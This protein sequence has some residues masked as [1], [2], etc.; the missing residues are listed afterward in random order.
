MQ[1]R[2]AIV[3]DDARVREELAKLINRA[4]GFRCVGTYADGET[5]LS[6]IPLKSPM[7][8]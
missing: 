6:E 1:V 3:E 5:A 8:S 7:S 4:D 2:V